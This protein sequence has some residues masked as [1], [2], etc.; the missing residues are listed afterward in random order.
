MNYDVVR[1]VLMVMVMLDHNDIVRNV[2]GVNQ[3]FLPMTFHVAGFLLLPF[4]VRPRKLSGPM[5]RDHAI[6]YL[7]PFFFAVLFYAAAFHV[8]VAKDAFTSQTLADLVAAL[9]FADPWHLQVATG[10]IVLWFLPALLSVVLL[11]AVYDAVAFPGRA[12]ILA[13]ALLVHLAVGA[14][15][16]AFKQYAPQGFLIALYIF[17]LGVAMRS[18]LPWL[19]EARRPGL[20]AASCASAVLACWAFERGRE[21]EVATLVL[22]TLREPLTV[23]ATDVS[24]L[25]FLTVLIIASRRLA[26]LPAFALV[27][28]YSLL[29]YL[30]HPIFYK[31][32]L[33]AL[34][35]VAGPGFLLYWAVAAASVVA[36]ACASLVAAWAIQACEPARKLITPRGIQ[37]WKEASPFLK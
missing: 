14:V 31:P 15:P 34:L 10:F 23:L 4:I 21:V 11:M 22:P 1:G 6:R 7:T 35:R 28:R 25:G 2:R 24:D 27:G 30:L 3:W 12:A 26:A 5:V 36:V 32:I 37:D 29:V 18:V 20:I 33:A 19:G 16:M 13:V 9:A 17:P 8:V